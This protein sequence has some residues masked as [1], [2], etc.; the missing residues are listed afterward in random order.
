MLGACCPARTARPPRSLRQHV[1]IMISQERSTHKRG[2]S[3]ITVPVKTSDEKIQ[4]RGSREL[5]SLNSILVIRSCSHML[6][7]DYGIKVCPHAPSS[8]GK[9]QQQSGISISPP[10]HQSSLG[11]PEASLN[12]PNPPSASSRN[13]HGTDQITAHHPSILIAHSDPSLDTTCSR[14]NH[15]RKPAEVVDRSLCR[16]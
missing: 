5:Q 1:W 9:K 2:I 10:P 11:I 7:V 3:K 8:K 6:H 15:T 14:A 4:G 12:A 16:E 13:A